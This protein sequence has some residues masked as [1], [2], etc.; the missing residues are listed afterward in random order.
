M[1]QPINLLGNESSPYLRQHADNPVHWRPWG[2]SA[3]DE[4]QRAGKPILLSVG[5]AACHWCHVM[6]HECFEDQEVADLMNSC[7]VNIKV[8]REE[9]PDIDQ[10][11][12]AA[13]GA[14][15][16]QGGWPLT[17]FL[18][19]EGKPFW[20]G[21]YFPKN[22]RYGRPG[23]VD[24]L[25]SID[26]VWRDDRDRVV[27]NVDALTSHV[28]N[29]LDA[30]ANPV[31]L[32]RQLFDQF[33]AN[34]TG[35]IDIEKGGLT[36]APKFPS[37]P[38]MDTLWLSWLRNGNIQHR[39]AFIKSLRMM[40]QGGI[41][42]HL[43]GGLS[44]YSVDDRWLVPHFEKM[45]YDN[46]QFIRHATYAYAETKD[47]LFRLRIEE[48]IDW[49]KREMLANG[50]CFASSLDADSEGE[51][52]RFYVWAA[53]E[54]ADTRGSDLFCA[55]Y[56]VTPE[57]NWEGK[58]ILNRLKS[59][60]L[61]DSG[62]EESLKKTR[63]I[64]FNRRE[65]RIH[66]QR[67]DKSLTD[68]NG[69]MIRALAEAARLLER[70][71]WLGLALASYRS[72]SES[73]VDG[74]LPHSVLEKSRL[75]PCLSSDYASMI[76]AAI[77]LYEATYEKAFLDD[78]ARWLHSLDLWHL[79]EDGNH[80]L[81]ASDSTDVIIRVRGDQDEA[82]PSATGQIIEAITR[83]ATATTDHTLQ[84]RAEQL[85]ENALGRVLE[86]RYGQAGVINSA[87]LLL[88]PMKL[89]LVAPDKDHPLLRLAA[90]YPDP[91]RIDIWIKFKEAATIELVPGSGEITIKKPAAYLCRGFICLAPVETAEALEALLKPQP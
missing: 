48:T 50:Q 7:Y 84:Q 76:N 30:Q 68:W 39:D 59:P 58:T 12:M 37:A 63:S 61:L 45:L 55:T 75:F 53:N 60:D 82:I 20:G 66:P 62:A 38:F 3:I 43:G 87:S 10:I 4:A 14:M 31:A 5:Y 65:A 64:L 56:D 24:V 88:E 25:Q 9:R 89:V 86:Q 22:S 26:R 1:N 40:L 74:R 11:Y 42:D 44:R 33:A 90:R 70:D 17:M 73:M 78:A 35:M 6:A 27:Q 41:Y 36:G 72:I 18:T 80:A 16:E 69:L 34:I 47:E 8:D 13:L 29:R 32:D 19:P 46:A 71:D 91:R 85:A 81:S 57:G 28:R 15:G 54:I 79:T 83:L 51:E 23:F 67:D 2:K 77:S 21:T 49:L 52:G